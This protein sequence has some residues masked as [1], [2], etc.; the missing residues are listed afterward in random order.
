MVYQKH[1]I[2]Y[3]GPNYLWVILLETININ[4]ITGKYEL[5]CELELCANSVHMNSW[6][7]Y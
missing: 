2:D 5:G 3:I 7:N 1:N 6:N 4:R